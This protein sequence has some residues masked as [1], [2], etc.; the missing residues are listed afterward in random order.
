MGNK[1][2]DITEYFE[3]LRRKYP[4]LDDLIETAKSNSQK[5]SD[6]RARFIFEFSELDDCQEFWQNIYHPENHEEL[7]SPFEADGKFLVGFDGYVLL[8][9][10]RIITMYDG[11]VLL[12]NENN[13]RLKEFNL[14]SI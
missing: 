5:A 12:C 8:D 11:W 7:I 6:V 13:G 1:S 14:T 10:F 3:S 4:Q 9:N 2:W